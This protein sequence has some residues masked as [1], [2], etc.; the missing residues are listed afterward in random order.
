MKNTTVHSLT[1]RKLVHSNIDGYSDVLLIKGYTYDEVVTLLYVNLYAT[2]SIK[3]V[4]FADSLLKEEII[5]YLS[6]DEKHS[7]NLVLNKAISYQEF[8]NLC[9]GLDS[10]Y[11]SKSTVT[12]G[13]LINL[14]SKELKDFELGLSAI[15]DK[16]NESTIF[17]LV[18]AVII[19]NNY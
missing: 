11:V 8:L 15:A 16:L 10:Y 4:L 7:N 2:Y 14:T 17:R 12:L 1:Y 5:N 6:G 9:D 19:Q 3:T 13:L 18:V